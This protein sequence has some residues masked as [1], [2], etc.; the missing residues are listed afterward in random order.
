MRTFNNSDCKY[1]TPL[2]KQL[3]FS[4]LVGFIFQS[5]TVFCQGAYKIGIGVHTSDYKE[6]STE[7][8]SLD[9]KAINYHAT[10]SY[11]LEVPLLFAEAGIGL[12]L[13]RYEIEERSIEEYKLIFPIMAGVKIFMFDLKT[14][15]MARMNANKNSP[16]NQLTEIDRI[17]FQYLTGVNVRFEKISIGLDY[18]S[19]ESFLVEKVI[20][21]ELTIDN[22]IRNRVFMT[23]YYKF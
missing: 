17:T 18:L 3:I 15:V 20:N 9:N 23:L 2:G 5:T 4:L 19:S 13:D 22:Q 6:L 11:R 7:D 14:G 10:V 21:R 8:I 12:D 1:L 16:I